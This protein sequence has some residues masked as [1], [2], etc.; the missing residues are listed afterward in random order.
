[1]E[2][3]DD[4][5]GIDLLVPSAFSIDKPRRLEPD[6]ERLTSFSFEKLKHR[7]VVVIA[8]G[9]IYRGRFVGAD[10]EELYVRGEFRWWVLPLATVTTVRRDEDADDDDDD[11]DDP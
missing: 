11:L 10:E 9:F 7:A 3:D 5:D 4:D 1:M 8:N 6:P 2:G